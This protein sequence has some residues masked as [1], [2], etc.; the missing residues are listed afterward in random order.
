MKDAASASWP[1]FGRACRCKTRRVFSSSG[2]VLV[3]FVMQCACESLFSDS[4]Y[5]KASFTAG[6]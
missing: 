3:K 5:I 1:F 2:E 6:E 4:E